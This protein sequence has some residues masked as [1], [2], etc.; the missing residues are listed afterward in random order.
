MQPHRQRPCGNNNIGTMAQH[1]KAH[2]ST[3]AQ[4][5]DLGVAIAIGN[6]DRFVDTEFFGQTGKG[7]RE[8][9]VVVLKRITDL[10]ELL[11]VP[12]SRR[13]RKNSF[14]RAHHISMFDSSKTYADF[15]SRASK[16]KTQQV[17]PAGHR[18][19]ALHIHQRCGVDVFSTKKD[20]GENIQNSD[21]LF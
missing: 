5:A 16:T 13:N 3:A 17:T 19:N 6:D 8:K 12:P 15:Q 2:T 21:S 18:L 9:R 4:D 1:D 11:P 10:H 7:C 14:F 20:Q